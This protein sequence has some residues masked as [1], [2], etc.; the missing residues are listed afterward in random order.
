VLWDLD[1]TIADSRELHWRA[2]SDVMGAAGYGVTERQFRHSFG[3]RN[4]LIIGTWLPGAEPGL[5]QHLGEDKEV[6]FRALVAA[7]GLE[8]L[9]G[10]HTWIERLAAAGWRQAIASS[11]PRENVEVMARALG[12]TTRMA[13]LV[14]AEDVSHGKP[15][16]EV[17]LVTAARLGVPAARCVVVEDAPAGI[18][19][20]RRAAMRSIGVGGGPLEAADVVA[21][22]LADLPRD[23]FERL[24]PQR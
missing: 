9:P 15:D 4:D 24:V 11:A 17:F 1:G 14:S 16:P 3:Q 21:A 7:E 6:R 19:A 2:W 5:I 10:V 12:L 22:S 20:A 23:T 13:V 8:P 18:E